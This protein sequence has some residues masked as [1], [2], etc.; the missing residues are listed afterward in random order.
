MTVIARTVPWPALALLLG[1]VI[2]TG[3]PSGIGWTRDPRVTLGAGI[4]VQGRTGLLEMV[5]VHFSAD[6]SQW[7]D[8]PVGLVYVP[9]TRPGHRL[10]HAWIESAERGRISTHDL[11]P[12]EPSFV[13]ITGADGGRWRDVAERVGK[14]LGV[15]VKAVS[16]AAN[17]DYTDID[18]HWAAVREIS[19][20]GAILVRPD[21]HI[22]WRAMTGV[23]DPGVE[24]TTALTHILGAHT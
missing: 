23:A 17:G 11:T 16:I 9:T 15:T 19:D 10:P 5:G 6:L 18:G 2:F 20:D 24:L 12:V 8:D 7:W 13:L 22:G 14:G 1:D 21:N 3:T 4:E